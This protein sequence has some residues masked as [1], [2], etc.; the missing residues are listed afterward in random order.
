MERINDFKL[1]QL[2]QLQTEPLLHTKTQT[3]IPKQENSFEQ[4]LQQK[5]QQSQNQLQFSKHSQERIQ[6]RG[7]EVTEDLL[8]QMN[9]AADSARQ[10]GAKDVV[11]IT[12]QA[13]FVVSVA[14][15]T[16]ITAMNGNEMKQNIFTKIDGAVLL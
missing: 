14:N 7:I 10:K 12:Q 3:A 1:R 4:V 8:A 16:V 11:M 9:E 2:Q 5:L 13:A 15:N 6:Q